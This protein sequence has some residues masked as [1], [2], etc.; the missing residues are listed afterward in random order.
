MVFNWFWNL[1]PSNKAECIACGNTYAKDAM[2]ELWYRFE[3]DDGAT[4]TDSLYVCTPCVEEMAQHVEEAVTSF[5][6]EEF[7]VELP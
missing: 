7:E 5:D 6:G 3:Q 2:K 4:G 1:F